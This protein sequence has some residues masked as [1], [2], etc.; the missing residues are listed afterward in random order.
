DKQWRSLNQKVDKLKYKRNKV[1][2]EINK[3]KKAGKS[4]KKKIKEMK[5]VAQKIRKQDEKIK[6]KADQRDKLRYK[7]GNIL[8]KSVPAGA[9]EVTVRTFGKKPKFKFTPKSHTQLLEDLDIADIER[10][11][12]VAGS[13]FYYLKNELVLLNLALQTFAMNYL[14][15]KKYVPMY[16]P[17]M[18]NRKA[19]EGAAELADFETMLYKLQGEDLFLIATAEQTLAGYHMNE[20]I[21]ETKLP[22]KFVGFSTNFRREAGSHGI[23]TK[24]IFRVHQFDKVEQYVLCKPEN[25]WKM[26]EEMIKNAEAIFKALKIPYRV[27][28]IPA[29]DMNDNA[30]K[31]YDIEAWMPAQQKYREVVSCS[32]CTDYQSRKLDIKLQRKIG[33]REILHVLNSTLCATQRAIVAIL[34]NF[35]QKDGSV[36]IPKPLWKYTGFKVIKPKKTKTKKK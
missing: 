3:L 10:A 29:E 6:L 24:G 8:H 1:S 31:K 23:D 13:R 19:I 34:E 15:K 7:I 27:V 2:E 9:E 35:Q 28:N 5:S 12:K 17:F 36:K 14:Y 25:S 4:T 16:T 18:M 22:I 33:K 11:A 32:N 26:H 30:A 21:N 20:I